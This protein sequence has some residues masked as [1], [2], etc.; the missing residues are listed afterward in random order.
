MKALSELDCV[1]GHGRNSH[2]RHTG[3]YDDTWGC[4][5]GSS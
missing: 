4:C 1:C 3:F 5:W 2:T